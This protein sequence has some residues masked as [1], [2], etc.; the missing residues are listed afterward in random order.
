MIN[1]TLFTQVHLARDF[2]EEGTLPLQKH[3][4]LY[5]SFTIKEEHSFLSVSFTPIL[6][7]ATDYA[8]HFGQLKPVSFI[9][10]VFILKVLHFL[11]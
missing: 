4:S 3:F 7:G 2:S 1:L 11:C 8:K 6:Q 10:C 9:L 5:F